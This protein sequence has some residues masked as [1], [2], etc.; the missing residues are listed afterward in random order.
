MEQPGPRSAHSPGSRFPSTAAPRASPA[1]KGKEKSS[2]KSR[3]KRP[4]GARSRG[5]VEPPGP[6]VPKP[7]SPNKASS[8]RG[9]HASAGPGGTRHRA[10]L[11]PPDKGDGGWRVLG[12]QEP[13]QG[14]LPQAGLGCRRCRR[15]P[16]RSIA[17]RRRN[18]SQG[19]RKEGKEDKSGG[20]W[21]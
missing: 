9:R 5:K 7:G 2:E 12:D 21:C 14:L 4:A 16:E 3:K 20:V 6:A 15:G 1:A 19:N 13:P 10:A 17:A 18:S 11:V 8:V